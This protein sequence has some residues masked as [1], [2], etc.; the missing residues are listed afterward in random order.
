MCGHVD[1]EQGLRGSLDGGDRGGGGRDGEGGNLCRWKQGFRRERW[2]GRRAALARLAWTSEVGTLHWLFI[3]EQISK[4]IEA[5]QSF[6]F[7]LVGSV[8]R[9][10][11]TADVEQIS[12]FDSEFLAEE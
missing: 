12:N 6:Q 1:W 11:A 7:G 2:G 5:Q 8:W 3:R 10:G 4:K 9:G